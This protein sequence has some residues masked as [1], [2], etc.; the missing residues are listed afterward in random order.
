[1]VARGERGGGE[2]GE[3]Q[4]KGIKKYKLPAIKSISHRDVAAQG[5]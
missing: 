3:K 2:G 4:V 5:I 1:M